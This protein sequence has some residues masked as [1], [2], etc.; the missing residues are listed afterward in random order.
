MSAQVLKRI[1]EQV[2]SLTE[3]EKIQLDQYLKSK[4]FVK[5][6]PP[7]WKDIGGLASYQTSSEDAQTVISNLRK[8]ADQKR[9]KIWQKT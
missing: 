1:I 2:E 4:V 5:K 9:E 8:E 7:K 3:E 6:I